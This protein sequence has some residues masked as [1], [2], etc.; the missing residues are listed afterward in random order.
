VGALQ[1]IQDTHADQ[2]TKKRATACHIHVASVESPWSETTQIQ[3]CMYMQGVL[4]SVAKHT[5]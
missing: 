4:C 5:V 3:K 2:P 1:N